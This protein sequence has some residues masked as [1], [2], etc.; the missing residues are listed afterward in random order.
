MIW[1]HGFMQRH[2]ATSI[3]INSFQFDLLHL[4]Y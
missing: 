1:D 3:S 2:E 4:S